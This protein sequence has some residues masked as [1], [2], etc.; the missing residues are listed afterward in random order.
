MLLPKKRPWRCKAYGRF[1]ASL[2]CA[3]TGDE[4]NDYLGIDPHHEP[5]KGNSGTSTKASDERQIPI[6]HDLH[7]RMETGGNSRASVYAEYGKD[8]E[9]LIAQTQAAWFARFQTRPWLAP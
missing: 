7:V 4:G 5:A 9:E 3:L 6:R 2:D 1:V 8:P